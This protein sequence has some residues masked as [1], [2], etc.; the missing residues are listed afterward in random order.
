MNGAQSLIRTLLAGGIDTCFANPGTSE[1]HFVAALDECPQM[2]CILG[3]QENVVS[4]AA[5]GYWRMADRP[6]VTL[7]HCGPGL[8]NSLANLHNARRAHSGMVNVVGDMATYHRALDAPLTADTEGWARSV[9]RWLRVSVSADTVGRDAADGIVAAQ[10]NNGGISTLILPADTAWGAG[11]VPGNLAAVRAPSMPPHAAVRE[12]AELLKSG[13]NVL[14]LVGGTG[15]REAPLQ[16]A[17]DICDATGAKLLAPIANA[18]ITRGRGRAPIT[19][20]PYPMAQS[21]ALLKDFTDVILVGAESP[22]SFFPYPDKPS[23]LLPE[24][25]RIHRLATAEEDVPGALAALADELGASRAVL[26][27][28]PAVLGPASGAVSSEAVGQS[29]AALLP[30][31]AIVIDEGQTFARGMYP[32]MEGAAPHDWLHL[33][34][35]SIGIGPPLALGASVAAPDR[36]VVSLQAD[37]SALFTVQALWSQAREK[38]PITT[39]IFANRRYQILLAELGNVGAKAGPAALGMMDLHTPHIDWCGIARSFG[40]PAERADT[41]E[42]FNAL[43]A[44]SLKEPGPFLIELECP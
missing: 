40:V 31:D 12:A 33:T 28:S 21:L 19:R 4:G 9:S 16:T 26:P 24:G 42:R 8:A 29:L 43:F 39:I 5:D 23:H 3:L 20:I 37:G 14:L 35:G 15:L 17:H 44:A 30:D 41:M 2:R 27:P 25:C 22:I 6:A 18:R 38:A 1:M 34:G 13:G 36:R 10:Q 32:A 11:G 7:M